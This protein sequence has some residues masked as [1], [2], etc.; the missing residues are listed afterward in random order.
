MTS[1]SRRRLLTGAA[2]I[3]GIAVAVPGCS[4]DDDADGDGAAHDLGLAARAAG[5]EKLA[6]DT[7]TA[8]RAVTTQGRLGAAVPQALVE[9]LTAGG[10]HH[11]EHL[12]AWNRLLTAGRR[13]A[14]DAPDPNLRPIVDAAMAK[15]SDVLAAAALVLRVED[16]LSQT[17]LEAIPRLTTEEAT[18]TAAQILVVDHQHQAV[19]RYLLGLHPVGSG[20]GR[21]VRDFAPSE[22]RPDLLGR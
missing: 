3:A 20:V 9:L 11:R 21:D 5:L 7:Y 19:L 6:V 1:L 2:A 17:Y 10:S 15:L 22:P 14:V 8:V 4:G 18:R 13:R 12:A 16:H